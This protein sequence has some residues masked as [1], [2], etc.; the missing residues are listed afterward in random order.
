MPH[1]LFLS[2]EV[3]RRSVRRRN[4]ETHARYHSEAGFLKRT[5]L[6]RVVR[7]HP[8]AAQAKVKEYLRAL[9]IPARVHFQAQQFVCFDG[10]GAVILQSVGANLVDDAY[11][12]SLLLLVDDGTAPLL[13][14]KFHSRLELSPAV[15]TDRAERVARHALRVNAYECRMFCAQGSFN[16]RNELLF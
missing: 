7:H 13:G 9:V 11:A 2:T 12:A 4:F 3:M 6:R 1:P 5:N 14:D 8:H 10:V 15:A 16:Q